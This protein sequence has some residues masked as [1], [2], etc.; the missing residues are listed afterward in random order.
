[1]SSQPVPTTFPMAEFQA[2]VT[3]CMRSWSALRTAVEGGWGGNDSEQKADDLRENIYNAMG[4]GRR[5]PALEVH[6]L[7]DNLAIY[8]EEEFAVQ[9]EDSSEK[10]VAQTL[11][12]LYEE[13]CQGSTSLAESLVMTALK[14]DQQIAAAFPVQIQSTEHDDDEDEDDDEDDAMMDT[15]GNDA[16]VTMSSVASAPPQPQAQPALQPQQPVAEAT[17]P[18][19]SAAEYAAQSVFAKP[20]QPKAPRKP[21]EETPEVQMD[22]DGFA[23]VT[24]GRRKARS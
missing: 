15:D 5:Q 17:L 16:G 13:C 20:K 3:A 18:V 8:M 22:E 11:F 23:P 9:L 10:Q 21:R 6:D 12:R 24:K 19:V 1:M 14:Y 4:D 2:G 7:E